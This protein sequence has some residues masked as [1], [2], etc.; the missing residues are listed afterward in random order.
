M[1]GWTGLIWLRMRVHCRVFVNRV[2]IFQVHAKKKDQELK[3][4]NVFLDKSLLS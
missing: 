2:S 4:L 3:E 1:N